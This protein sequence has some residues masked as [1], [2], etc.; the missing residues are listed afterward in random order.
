MEYR[1][2]Y[3]VPLIVNDFPDDFIS[4]QKEEISKRFIFKFSLLDGDINVYFKVSATKNE[5]FDTLGFL[6]SQYG[7][8][9]LQN[10]ENAKIV[11][12]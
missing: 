1:I 11:S 5:S 12:L 6:R 9:C 10:F 2:T 3:I 7:Y 4:N 8:L